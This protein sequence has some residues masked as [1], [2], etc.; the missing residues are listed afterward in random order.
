MAVV[1]F[2]NPVALNGA[3]SV[4]EA[5]EARDQFDNDA[6]LLRAQL[7][8]QMTPEEFKYFDEIYQELLQKEQR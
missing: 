4:E 7:R 5:T 2:R 1:P 8:E 3:A 6:A